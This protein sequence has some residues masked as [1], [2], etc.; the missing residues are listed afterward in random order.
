[1]HPLSGDMSTFKDSELE[2]KVQDL[3]KKY[4]QTHNMEMRTQ[5]AAL[6]E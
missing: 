4:F 2:S 3:T 5:I 6:L 1:M